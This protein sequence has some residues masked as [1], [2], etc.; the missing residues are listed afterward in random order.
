MPN[1]HAEPES[2]EPIPSPYCDSIQR[3]TRN[4][5]QHLLQDMCVVKMHVSEFPVLESDIVHVQSDWKG[6]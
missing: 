1:V 6:K 2:K 3:D 5:T 4:V